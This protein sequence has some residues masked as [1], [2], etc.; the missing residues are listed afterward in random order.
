MDSRTREALDLS[1]VLDL[2]VSFAAGEETRERI[3]G[4]L[5]GDDGFARLPVVAEAMAWKRE[6]GLP[7][8]VGLEKPPGV[9]P[10]GM[11]LNSEDLVRVR[12][13]LQV[14]HLVVESLS[15]PRGRFPRLAACF[16][17]LPLSREFSQN[18][19]QCLNDKGEIQDTASQALFRLRKEKETLFQNA[20]VFMGRLGEDA[21]PEHLAPGKVSV[22]QDRLVLLVRNQGAQAVEG[23]LHGRSQKGGT[24][25]VEPL[26]AI[27]WNNRLQTIAAEEEAEVHRI[28]LA[29]TLEF[30]E[31]YPELCSTYLEMVHYDEIQAMA[32]LSYAWNGTTPT[33]TEKGDLVLEEARHPLLDP[34]LASLRKD[35]LG[36]E[37]PHP[38]L[39][40]L[41]VALSRPQPGLVLSGPNAGGKSVALKTVGLLT[42]LVHLGYPIPAGEGS[43]IPKLKNFF[44]SLGDGQSLM[45][46]LST[47]SARMSHLA[48]F[49][50]RDP[51]DSLV[52]LDEWGSG[53]NP[54]EGQGLARALVDY[55]VDQGAFL[56]ATTHHDG[57]KAYAQAHSALRN[58]AMEFNEAT[59]VPTIEIRSG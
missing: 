25:Y 12:R 4:Q 1:R 43:K 44:A 59:L 29:L 30:S 10:R 7:C 23:I 51:K 5:P 2:A 13:L 6:G 54:E 18:L 37:A 47:Y 27:S 32:S 31:V 34:A 15:Q 49:L 26:E 45:D 28:L 57:L 22:W 35:V 11:F 42:V 46:S 56:V 55:F 39:V 24:L 50:E 41:S 48:S 36:D 53:T 17:G 58:A 9:P 21:G 40:P 3:L 20:L 38:A 52:L 16:G 19:D 8:P 14:T 33:V